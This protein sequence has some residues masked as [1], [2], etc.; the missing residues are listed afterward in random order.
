MK[1]ALAIPKIIEKHIGTDLK[2]HINNEI[3]S[4]PIGDEAIMH[5]HNTFPALAQHYRV[6]MWK[7]PALDNIEKEHQN[8][9]NGQKP[10]I[11]ATKEK[12]TEFVTALISRIG[13]LP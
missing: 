9:I 2:K 8:T 4:S 13:S 3:L 1:Y 12:Y 10:D 5:S 11:F 6:P 7:I